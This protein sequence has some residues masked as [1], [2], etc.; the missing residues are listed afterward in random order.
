MA[1]MSQLT[2]SLFL[3]LAFIFLFYFLM[4]TTIATN[5]ISQENA[6]LTIWTNGT[7][8]GENRTVGGGLSGKTFND[9]NFYFLSN[10]TNIT[11]AYLNSTFGDGNCTILF[12]TSGIFST[13]QP[14]VYQPD[15]LWSFNRTFNYKGNQSFLVSCT[16][17]F[18]N[19]T[20]LTDFFYI[21]NT[22][23]YLSTISSINFVN[24]EDNFTSNNFSQYVIED[25][26]NDVL[27]YSILNI[28]S[29]KHSA[30]TPSYYQNWIWVNSSTGLIFV[31]ATN[32]TEAANYGVTIQVLDSGNNGE[33]IAGLIKTVSLT[34]N[35]E[36][37]RPYFLNLNG[38]R[39]IN[40]TGI[41][42]ILTAADEE[43]DNPYIFNVSFL[44]CVHT[45][46]N[47][48]TGPDNCTLFNL[49]TY[50]STS[51]NISFVPQANQKGVY[52]INFSVKDSRNATYYEVV[53]WTITWNDPPYFTY[54]C[55]NERNTSEDSGFSCY[56]NA[57]D[58]DELNNL[59]FITNY[60]WFTFD[61]AS[62]STTVV[63]SGGN[64][65]ALVS[66]TPADLQVGNWTINLTVRD[67]GATNAS[68]EINS[69]I[70]SFFIGNVNDSVAISDIPDITVFTSSNYTVFVNATDDDLLIPDKSVLNE[71]L[72]F[73]TN[74]SLVTVSNQQYFS[75]TN[76]SQVR[77]NI[78]PV[79]L[80]T[81]QTV[82]N[83]SVQDKYNNSIAS[84][85]FTIT[86]IDNSAPQWSSTMET[87]FTLIENVPFFLNLSENITDS[88][89]INFTF[90][91]LGPTCGS[92]TCKF[93]SFSIGL[94]TGII[95]FTT[96]D[97]DVGFHQ[98][99]IT[100]TDGKTPSTKD[101]NFTVNNVPDAPAYYALFVTAPNGTFSSGL[102]NVT[103]DLPQVIRL[104]ISDDDLRIQQTSFYSE[105]F[106]LGLNITGI[107]NSLFAFDS[108]FAINPPSNNLYQF[109]AIF[110]PKK[111]DVGNYNI[112]INITDASG[113]F[114]TL[115]Y[116]LTVTETLHPPNITAPIENIDLSILDENFFIDVNATDIEDGADGFPTNLTFRIQSLT[117]GGNFLQVNSSTGVINFTSNSSLAGLWQF[118]LIVNDT[119]GHE[120][121]ESFNIT[122]YDYPSIL[123]P[124][125]SHTFNLIENVTTILNF[126]VNH[127]VQNNLSYTL[128]IN[129]ITVNSTSGYG[130]ASLFSWGFTPN[131]TMETTCIGLAYLTL[132]VSNSKLSNSTSWIVNISH[133]N[134][135]LTYLSNISDQSGGTPITLSLANYFY[136]VDATDTCV[137]Q[138]IGFLSTQ[139]PDSA[140]GGAVSVAITNWS[141]N[142]SIPAAVFSV[143]SDGSANFS[144]SAFEYNLSNSSQAITQINTNNFSVS[145]IV[146]E[147][148][149]VQQTSSGGG[150]STRN[151]IISLKIL[152][153]EPVSAK[154]KDKLIIPLGLEN[155]GEV[156]LRRIYLDAVIAKDGGIRRDLIAS[157]DRSYFESLPKGTKENLTLVVD[158]DTESVGL[159]EVT[160]NATVE[161]PEYTDW[162]KL[163]IEIEEDRSVLEKIIFTEE[164]LI[165]NPQCAELM[166]LIID[167]KAL[168]NEGKEKEAIAKSE[169]A[170]KACNKAITQPPRPRIYER[171]GDQFIGFTAIA[172]LVAFALGF[173]YYAYKKVTLNRQLTP[174]IRKTLITS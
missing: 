48:P 143:T 11:G 89:S 161:S 168:F 57:S 151:R 66:F 78:D 146:S 112:T 22:G 156:E 58:T 101:F 167:A 125:T 103:E 80:G 5:T 155:D 30:T 107:N 119:D 166:D 39:V 92:T 141:G 26:Y 169:E 67:T 74:N 55:D 102:I 46:L 71:T 105:S 171:L 121:N 131:F 34:V 124:I 134:F 7:S 40:K 33:D 130:N 90:T 36:N 136:D 108:G 83:V 159:F 43:S 132:N 152:V 62:N 114:T 3:V 109:S 123:Q 118:R 145:L 50:N 95:N 31:N 153:P 100:A 154:Q 111:S 96:N 19:I 15:G 81:G 72:T 170:L 116:N 53:N 64:A 54:T 14:M 56:I 98:V 127:T 85:L 91:L 75:G 139:V 61:S 157:F 6:T 104:Q 122:I 76:R 86:V 42:L 38:D 23:P 69:T 10:L 93:D 158:I 37:D 12:N 147:T 99:R 77:L 126:T 138:N 47:P 120:G 1:I 149:Q 21:L 59:T 27:T 87:N 133:T 135:P 150:G 18:G 162:A 173:A 65:S 160:I 24:E 88:D 17:L 94:T 68:V 35:P 2:K 70:F 165:G 41:E 4:S 144:L 29:T 142:A 79:P 20:N 49:T 128:I 45:A 137:N 113:N 73:T 82:I 115:R 163:Y 8:T 97:H 32:D 60:T 44:T 117:A 106:T 110:T 25:D 28:T 16:S 9:Y 129:N 172:S 84:D 148:P 140:S 63:T 52:E 51:T 164:F 13:P 174:P